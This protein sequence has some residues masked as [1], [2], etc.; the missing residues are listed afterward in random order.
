VRL[1]GAARNFKSWLGVVFFW[2][3]RSR[4]IAK[5]PRLSVRV[6]NFS[7]STETST[8]QASSVRKAEKT[9][10]CQ[11]HNDIFSSTIGEFVSPIQVRSFQRRLY[12]F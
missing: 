3:G 11:D 12:D 10:Y 6:S 8:L 7:G 9:D 1:R 5:N 4:S 2:L